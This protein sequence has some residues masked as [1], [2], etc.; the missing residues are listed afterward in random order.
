MKCIGTISWTPEF[1]NENYIEREA[2]S[3]RENRTMTEAGE[4]SARRDNNQAVR[5]R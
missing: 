5:G 4:P 3:G 2:G 1:A